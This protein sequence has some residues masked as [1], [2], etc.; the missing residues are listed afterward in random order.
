MSEEEWIGSAEER[1]R[2]WNL[3]CDSRS[4]RVRASFLGIKQS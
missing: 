2:E 4:K 1:T 3:D